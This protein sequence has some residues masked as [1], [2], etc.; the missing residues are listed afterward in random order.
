MQIF[1]KIHQAKKEKITKQFCSWKLMRLYKYITFQLEVSMKL[2]VLFYLLVPVAHPLI[3][4]ILKKLWVVSI[5]FLFVTK[6]RYCNWEILHL[7]VNS[8]VRFFKC[9]I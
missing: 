3:K 1:L 5:V 6:M 8:R 9:P 2:Y 7:T 4:V